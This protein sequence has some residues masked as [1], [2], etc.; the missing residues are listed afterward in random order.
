MFLCIMAWCEFFT[1]YPCDVEKEKA[2]GFGCQDYPTL[3]MAGSYRAAMI[4]IRFRPCIN[5]VIA[6]R[7]PVCISA[8]SITW[9]DVDTR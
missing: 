5:S 8:S 2:T 3:G 6:A 4:I 7:L 9:G 1:W